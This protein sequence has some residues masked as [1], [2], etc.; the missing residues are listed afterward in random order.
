MFDGC[1]G[2]PIFR[3]KCGKGV[4]RR[5]RLRMVSDELVVDLLHT[6]TVFTR[7]VGIRERRR[8]LMRRFDVYPRFCPRTDGFRRREH[9]RKQQNGERGDS[10]LA[11]TPV[12][13]PAVADY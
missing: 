1:F 9:R 2:L 8:C 7:Y 5:A 13:P 4:L 10:P 3:E 11:F 12:L 6:Q